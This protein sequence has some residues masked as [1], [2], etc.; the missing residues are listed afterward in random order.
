MSVSALR[1]ATKQ[2]ITYLG[3][4]NNEGYAQE[5][6]RYASKMYAAI[7]QVPLIAN[8]ES[9]ESKEPCPD[10][11]HFELAEEWDFRRKQMDIRIILWKKPLDPLEVYIS[12]YPVKNLSIFTPKI[13][14]SV[15]PYTKNIIVINRN[16]SFDEIL[17]QLLIFALQNNY[18]TIDQE[19]LN[20]FDSFVRKYIRVKGWHGNTSRQHSPMLL[21]YIQNHYWRPFTAYSFKSYLKKLMKVYLKEERRKNSIVLP[22]G[23]DSLSTTKETYFQDN[24]SKRMNNF[25]IFRNENGQETGMGVDRTVIELGISRDRIYRLIRIGRLK[26]KTIEGTYV[27]DKKAQRNLMRITAEQIKHKRD[28][29]RI[30]I[31]RGIKRNSACKRLRRRKGKNN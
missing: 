28:I 15:K 23:I 4:L 25:Q 29:D 5:R 19:C 12:A 30:A 7:K 18:V 20:L 31:E 2:L 14:Q 24:L 17:I 27:L 26:I 6:C 21:F 9:F 1:Y 22:R 16:I 10:T 8:I 3:K 13:K 11:D